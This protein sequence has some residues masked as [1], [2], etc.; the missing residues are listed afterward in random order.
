[1][2][3]LLHYDL[4]A[5]AR[6][7]LSKEA[8]ITNDDASRII[9]CCTLDSEMVGELQDLITFFDG[10]PDDLKFLEALIGDEFAV[11]A[12]AAKVIVRSLITLYIVNR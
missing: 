6:D 4:F 12:A 5:S 8:K 1:M 2:S 3:S 7:K 11:D 10:N 9:A